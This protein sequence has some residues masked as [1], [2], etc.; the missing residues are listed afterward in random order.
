MP[1]ATEQA[2]VNYKLEHILSPDSSPGSLTLGSCSYSSVY[3]NCQ[4]SATVSTMTSYSSDT[5]GFLN[6]QNCSSVV[7][8]SQQPMGFEKSTQGMSRVTQHLASDARL[9]Y[10]GSI[11]S[12]VINHHGN[13]ESERISQWSQ[14][15]KGTA[16]PPVF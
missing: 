4:D 3:P 2:P 7:Y 1:P 10:S 16:P 15:L 13:E 9:R 14:W 12:H 5:A 8:T 11:P 6:G